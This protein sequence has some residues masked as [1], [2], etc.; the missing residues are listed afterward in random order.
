MLICITALLV[1]WEVLLYGISSI[2][3]FILRQTFFFT[4]CFWDQLLLFIFL[5]LFI[6]EHWSAQFRSAAQFLWPFIYSTPAFF[7]FIK[8][9]FLL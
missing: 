9:Y 7:I 3:F 8:P 2:P 5:A 1:G 4:F 6:L